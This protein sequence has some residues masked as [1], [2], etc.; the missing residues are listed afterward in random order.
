MAKVKISMLKQAL[1]IQYIRLMLCKSL[2]SV[3]LCCIII[4]WNVVIIYYLIFLQNTFYWM[5]QSMGLHL[6]FVA[7]FIGSI[8]DVFLSQGKLRIKEATCE[9]GDSFNIFVS[10]IL[11]PTILAKILCQF[12]VFLWYFDLPQAKRHCKLSIRVA[13]R[14]S[15]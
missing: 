10:C 6:S 7:V 8:L 4:M 2:V 5:V 1:K 13:S 11:Q 14:V 12:A 3:I 15:E 9:S